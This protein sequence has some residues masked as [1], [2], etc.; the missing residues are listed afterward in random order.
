MYRAHI[1]IIICTAFISG[2]SLLSMEI[3]KSVPKSPLLFDCR[4]IDHLIRNQASVLRGLV[5]IEQ[6][7]HYCTALHQAMATLQWHQDIVFDDAALSH[8]EC[9]EETIGFLRKITRRN[10]HCRMFMDFVC[11]QKIFPRDSVMLFMNNSYAANAQLLCCDYGGVTPPL[12][13]A[14]WCSA[15]AH[16]NIHKQKSIDFGIRHLLGCGANVNGIDH[17]NR[18]PLHV[19]RSIEHMILLLAKKPDLNARNERGMTPLNY[20]IKKKE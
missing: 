9:N 5:F 16:D 18:T 19:V 4:N 1:Y 11:D 15:H 13:Y 2:V 8:R 17:K 7:G 6:N 14:L 12:H 20:H 3:V 10:K